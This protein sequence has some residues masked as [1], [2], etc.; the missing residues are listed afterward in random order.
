[1]LEY[2]PRLVPDLDLDR[3]TEDDSQAVSHT[4][5]SPFLSRS[6]LQQSAQADLDDI[7]I[8]ADAIKNLGKT[9]ADFDIELTREWSGVDGIQHDAHEDESNLTPVARETSN[10]L[11]SMLSFRSM[12]LAE[13]PHSDLNTLNI[14]SGD[15]G[16]NSKSGAHSVDRRFSSISEHS[17]SKGP[18]KVFDN[19][20]LQSALAFEIIQGG[21]FPILSQ[22]IFCIGEKNVPEI[23]LHSEGCIDL[24]PE[25]P[26]TFEDTL[27]EQ[28]SVESTQGT[29][30]SEQVIIGSAVRRSSLRSSVIFLKVR[31]TDLGL[32]P[33]SLP[34]KAF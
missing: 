30:V 10:N 22:S 34:V 9:L 14:A 5:D 32:G 27:G 25:A 1:M 8:D 24:F 6:T 18:A 23:S 11:M 3:G 7:L 12:F 19:I 4:A 33:Y 17:R 2:I 28:E 20:S 21:W 15:T 26:V 29:R 13:K 31:H 16:N